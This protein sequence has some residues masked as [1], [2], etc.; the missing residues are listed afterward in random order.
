MIVLFEPARK[1]FALISTDNSATG[2]A[3]TAWKRV[4]VAGSN[5]SN[6][7]SAGVMTV[8]RRRRMFSRD[9]ATWKPWLL[10]S[11]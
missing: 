10:K 7:N 6:S 2:S 4:E 3:D 8:K 1:T 11:W 5:V 9:L